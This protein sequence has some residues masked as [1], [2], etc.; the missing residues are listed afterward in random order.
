MKWFKKEE[1]GDADHEEE[2]TTV[3]VGKEATQSLVRG[4]AHETGKSFCKQIVN[5]FKELV[6]ETPDQDE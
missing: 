1:R 5:F 3:T 4:I 2:K 6:G